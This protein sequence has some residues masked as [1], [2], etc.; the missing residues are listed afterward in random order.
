[1]RLAL[2]KFMLPLLLLFSQQEALLHEL[3]H[4]GDE[5]AQLQSPGKQVPDSKPCGKCIVFAHIAGAVHSEVPQPFA[6]DLAYAPPE[7]VQVAS[8]AAETPSPR[9]RGPP[10]FL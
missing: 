1:M 8:I 5:L 3:G 4:V 9:S 10:H 2:L 6:Q 7:Q